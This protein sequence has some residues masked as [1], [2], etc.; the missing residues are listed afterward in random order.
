MSPP[1]R[2]KGEYRSA[3]HEGTPMSSIPSLPMH[4]LARWSRA[5]A[6]TLA[7]CWL[8]GALAGAVAQPAADTGAS[9]APAASSV[10]STPSTPM[11]ALALPPAEAFFRYPDVLNAELSPAGNRLAITTAKGANR[12]GLLVLELGTTTTVKRVALFNDADVL[13]FSWVG[14][15]RLVF[16]VADLESGSGQDQYAAP[17]LFGVDTDGANLRQLVA[18][19][20]IRG[21]IAALPIGRAGLDWN[22]VLLAVPEAQPG[23]E[24]DEVVIGE[25]SFQGNQLRAVIPRWLN[26]R[27]GRARSMDLQPPSQVQ[28]W[29]FDSAG[30]ARVAVSRGDGRQTIHWRAPGQGEWQVLADTDVLR[31][32]FTPRFVDDAGNLYVSHRSG[33]QGYTVLSRFDFE[34]RA[35]AAEPWVSTPGFDFSGSV[36][37]GRRGAAALGVRAETDAETTVWLDEG[38]RRLQAEADARLPGRVN[39]IS[40]RRCGA[41]DMV[42]LVRSWSDRDP[43]QLLLYRADQPE[44]ARWQRVGRVQ[45]GIDPAAMARVEFHRIRARDGR[46]LP[47]W[48]T[49]PAGRQPGAPGP[50]VVLVHGGPWVRGGHWAW[51]PMEQFLASRGY[52]VISPD[53]RGSAGYGDAHFKAGWKQW[54]RAMQDD[55][56]D[57]LLWA[58]AQ[59]LADDRA[60]IA[61]ASYG[62]YATLMGLVRHPALYRCGVAWVAVTDPFLYL[63]GSWW[64]N[65]DISSEGRRYRLP[66]MVGDVKA[67][68]EMLTAVSPVA[69]AARIQAP[70]LLAFGES[71]LRVPLA[72]GQRLREAMAK[73]GREPL[74]VTYPNEGH[75]WRLPATNTDFAKRVEKFLAEHLAGPAGR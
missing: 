40:C 32:P 44:D 45:E 16:S 14:N 67:D 12:V 41:A 37:G 18:R 4:L 56:A 63:E 29:L 73:A 34:R 20:S 72:H 68:A 55:V 57:A 23:V 49:L 60:C 24:P 65:D 1:G 54:G 70:L 46:D 74:W 35:P 51:R 8:A 26:V 53:F 10:S 25:L 11:A 19:R 52:L 50:A 62:G 71:D 38:M 33:P 22:H 9:A 75:S 30:Q 66:E 17:G 6:R 61:G 28:G 48:L 59:G 64:V 47:V 27:S 2:P 15:D 36:V 43:G 31:V 58:R 21:V 69:Q 7:A 13:R 39:R 42:A 3:Q 5:A